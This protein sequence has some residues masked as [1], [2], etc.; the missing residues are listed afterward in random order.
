[1]AYEGRLCPLERIIK[2]KSKWNMKW[3]PG[4][5]GLELRHYGDIVLSFESAGFM[6]C[7]SVSGL[8]LQA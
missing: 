4:D 6:S 7:D 5:C 3:K 1:M 2:R 8:D